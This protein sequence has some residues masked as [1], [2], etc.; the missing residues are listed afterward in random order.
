MWT[1]RSVSSSTLA[2]A[3]GLAPSVAWSQYDCPADWRDAGTPIDDP[4]P[5]APPGVPEAEIDALHAFVT[6]ADIADLETLL[7]ALPDWLLANHV[8]VDETRT[9]HRASVAHPRV[10]LFGSDARFL[11]AF[12]S[13][14][15][16]PAR[17]VLDL[18]ELQG[19]G[20]WKLRSLDFGTSPPALS[21]D[22]AACT[23]CHGDP[24]RPFWGSYPSWPGAFGPEQDLVTAA[25]ATRLN[26]IRADPAASDRFFALGVPPPFG[27]GAWEAG[28][29]VRLPGR[30]YPYTNTVF[31]LELGAAV[32][33]GAFRRLR[34]SPSFRELRDELLTLSYC[35]PRD[36]AA[37]VVSGARDAV[38]ATLA[39]SGVAPASR[40]VLYRHLGVDPDRAFS[41][42]RLAHEAPDPGWNVSTDTLPGLV[43]LLL[44]HDWMREDPALLQL[45]EAQPDLPSPFNAGC[46]DHVADTIRYKIHLGWTLRGAARQTSRAA[47]L[48]LDLLRATQGVLDPVRDALCP[49]LYERVQ[50]SPPAPVP[51]CD[52][53][54]DNDGD[55]AADFPADPGCASAASGLEDPACDDGIDN[56]RDGRVDLDDAHCTSASRAREASAPPTAGC[57]LGP[58][59]AFVV[60]WLA[61]RRARARSRGGRG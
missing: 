32:A 40:D 25:Q 50:S 28:D 14:P 2:L 4:Q 3:L 27:G 29:I 57:G 52:D 24:P 9:P 53:A 33:E 6:D 31:N 18:A 48:D 7:G 38:A 56:D 42:H 54:V 36:G 60:A 37:Y 1:L 11:L 12:G 16:D 45:L 13:D 22:D 8:F 58:E 35:A 10:L 20:H 34:A 17:E 21:P 41:L 49:F 44:L 43:N 55:G 5:I 19:D 23:S 30:A 15:D 46:F 59:L 26:E 39:A 51:A 47:G 61:R